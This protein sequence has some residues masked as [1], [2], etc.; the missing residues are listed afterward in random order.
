MSLFLKQHRAI[1]FSGL[2]LN[3]ETNIADMPTAKSDN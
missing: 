3:V 2:K 1:K